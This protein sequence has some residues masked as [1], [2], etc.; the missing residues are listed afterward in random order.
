ME[1]ELNESVKYLI[2]EIQKDI[3]HL[4]EEYTVAWVEYAYRKAL[5]EYEKKHNLEMDVLRTSTD[6]QLME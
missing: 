2:S 5:K 6:D 1:C 4:M 3:Y